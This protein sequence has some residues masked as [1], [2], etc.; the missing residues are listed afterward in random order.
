MPTINGVDLW[1]TH[2]YISVEQ[3]K[4]TN[5]LAGSPSDT[6]GYYEGNVAKLGC[7]SDR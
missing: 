5:G 7:K 2:R 1:N 3:E 6:L 4:V